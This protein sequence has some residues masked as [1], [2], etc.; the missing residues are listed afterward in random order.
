MYGGYSTHLRK[1]GSFVLWNAQGA[2][3]N[4][5]IAIL[6]YYRLHLYEFGHT[7]GESASGIFCHN[8]SHS[9]EIVIDSGLSDN[10]KKPL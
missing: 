2:L 1:T 4:E 10:G 7:T 9:A 3:I 6:M 8:A 5:F